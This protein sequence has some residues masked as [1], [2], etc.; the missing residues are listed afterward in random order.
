MIL[1]FSVLNRQNKIKENVYFS[2][3]QS[4]NGIANYLI[5]SGNTLQMV[6]L[7]SEKTKRVDKDNAISHLGKKAQFNKPQLGK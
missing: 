3:D 2:Y 6:C 4:A 7:F 1:P 5:S